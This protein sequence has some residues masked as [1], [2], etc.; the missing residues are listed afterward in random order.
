MEEVK[1][2][3]YKQEISS[4]KDTNN[5]KE[6]KKVINAA[7]G[8]DAKKI[9]TSKG[10]YSDNT[11]IYFIPMYK[12]QYVLVCA[13]EEPI[14]VSDLQN[15]ESASEIVE[16]GKAKSD[17]FR[18]I[19]GG[20]VKADDPLLNSVHSYV[21]GENKDSE[22]QGLVDDMLKSACSQHNELITLL[23]EE[24][25]EFSKR[26]TVVSEIQNKIFNELC[27]NQ[28]FMNELKPAID[29]LAQVYEEYDQTM[30]QI[31]AD[32]S[33]LDQKSFEVFK[34]INEKYFSGVNKIKEKYNQ[35]IDDKAKEMDILVRIPMGTVGRNGNNMVLICE[36]N[37]DIDL[38]NINNI[39]NSKEA[40]EA[41][42]TPKGGTIYGKND[43]N[44]PEQS[45]IFIKYNAEKETF[46][47]EKNKIIEA[48]TTKLEKAN[49]D[50]TN[51]RKKAIETR[52]NA[53]KEYMDVINKYQGSNTKVQA[54]IDSYN[55]VNSLSVRS[56]Q[57][58][59]NI[60]NHYLDTASKLNELVMEG[61]VSDDVIKNNTRFA[62]NGN[63]IN[64]DL[65]SMI[66]DLESD[67][68][69]SD[70]TMY[71]SPKAYDVDPDDIIMGNDG[72]MVTIEEFE[73]EVARQKEEFDSYENRDDAIREVGVPVYSGGEIM[74]FMKTDDV[75][76][77]EEPTVQEEEHND[78]IRISYGD[79]T[80]EYVKQPDVRES[81]ENLKKVVEEN[82]LDEVEL[83]P[84][85]K[86]K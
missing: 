36:G 38:S 57:N 32:K 1:L 31:D 18:S 46:N 14:D 56:I 34:K 41:G 69:L 59:D 5:S 27:K 8:Y 53:K 80:V 9:D 58:H 81:L 71:Y 49:I 39:K 33:S 67:L 16:L 76:K 6:V 54:L 50:I 23:K 40:K 79:G 29:G 21:S 62:L 30:A 75:E 45:D 52:D 44:V 78:E 4:Q 63:E 43:P 64:D 47:D 19:S 61:Q 24:E 51:R 12:S 37:Q 25:V 65:L 74:Y 13:S 26:S 11:S 85:S 82:S 3:E 15:C 7:N 20:R 17:S 66:K 55:K 72:K 48:F 35:E 28:D 77:E 60:M 2:D 83:E 42:L 86:V 73:E 22:M 84:D 68:E 70:T 10:M